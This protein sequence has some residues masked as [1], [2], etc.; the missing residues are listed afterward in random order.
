MRKIP[1][2]NISDGVNRLRSCGDR[3]VKATASQASYRRLLGEEGTS[4]IENDEDIYLA[5]MLPIY[6]TRENK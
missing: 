4:A 5:P 3:V 6:T 1:F 2:W